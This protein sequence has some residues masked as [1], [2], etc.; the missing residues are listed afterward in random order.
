MRRFAEWTTLVLFLG[1]MAGCNDPEGQAD[2]AMQS[3]RVAIQLDEIQTQL[4]TLQEQIADMKTS[5][6]QQESLQ[7]RPVVPVQP[8]PAPTTTAATKAARLRALAA[9]P[10]YTPKKTASK[11]SSKGKSYTNLA[12]KH[13]RVPV[14]VRV[15]QQALANAGVSPGKVD[16]KVGERTIAAIRAFQQKE[17]V[18]VDG[19]VGPNTWSRLQPYA[20]S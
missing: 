18:K 4:M 2:N 20:G 10:R 16:G 15:V 3:E 1:V 19:I 14:P 12:K 9:Q 11:S 5:S 7:L 13:I 6:S 17:G 8:A